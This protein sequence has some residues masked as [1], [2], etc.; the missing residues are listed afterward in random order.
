[1]ESMKIDARSARGLGAMAA[2]WDL[3]RVER[4]ERREVNKNAAWCRDRELYK[5]LQTSENHDAW[6][7]GWEHEMRAEGEVGPEDKSEW[8]C[9]DCGDSGTGFH[10][11]EVARL[12]VFDTSDS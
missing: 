9:T 2:R 5:G 7:E 4:G 12:R 1:M 6:M 11:C 8:S 3:R 10:A